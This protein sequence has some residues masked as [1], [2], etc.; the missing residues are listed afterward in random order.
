MAELLIAADLHIGNDRWPVSPE[1]YDRPLEEI[2]VYAGDNDIDAVIISGDFF[3]KRNPTTEERWRARLFI[4]NLRSMGIEVYVVAG[5]H[6]T[7]SMPGSISTTDLLD[8]VE[9]VHATQIHSLTSDKLG[10]HVV[11]LPWP[12]YR[13]VLA[14]DTLSK[15]ADIETQLQRAEQLVCDAIDKEIRNATLRPRIL[16]GHAHLYYG[17]TWDHSPESPRLLAGRDVL[18]PYNWLEERFDLIALGHIHNGELRGY[19]GSTQPTDFADNGPKYFWHVSTNA[20]KGLADVVKVRYTSALTVEHWEFR[21]ER[22]SDL[23]R[24]EKTVDIGKLTVQLTGEARLSNF[25]AHEWLRAHARISHGV[26]LIPPSRERRLA[27]LGAEA[28]DISSVPKALAL[29]MRSKGVQDFDESA[30]A[31]ALE[32]LTNASA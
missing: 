6:D 23:P 17:A 30:A 9:Y 2:L 27:T 8:D 19:V 5:N 21:A 26:T 13:K 29:W 31:E 16:V 28:S 20:G 12:H 14:G 22:E 18:L 3:H 10:A 4:G 7:F 15:D 11:S 25:Q 32:K 1:V 24:L